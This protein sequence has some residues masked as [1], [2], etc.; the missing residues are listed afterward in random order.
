MPVDLDN[1]RVNHGVFHVGIVR[2]GIEYP[3]K[4]IGLYPMAEPFEHRVPWAEILRQIPPGAA[5]PGNPQNRFDEKP[6]VSAG[7]ARIGLLAKAMRLD[8]LPLGIG[9]DKAI[10]KKLL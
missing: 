5:R 4:N 1:C 2:G 7:P 3:F 6:A 10:H 9:Q 8:L